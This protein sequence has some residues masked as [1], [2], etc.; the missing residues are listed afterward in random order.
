MATMRSLKRVLAVVA[1]FSCAGVLSAVVASGLPAGAASSGGSGSHVS[2]AA[3]V[4]AYG[5]RA[6]DDAP[7]QRVVI[8][9]GDGPV[10]ERGAA[11]AFPLSWVNP[12]GDDQA[13]Q[14]IAGWVAP[15]QFVATKIVLGRR[16]GSGHLAWRVEGRRAGHAELWLLAPNGTLLSHRRV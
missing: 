6:G 14:V 7:V 15:Q 5:Q 12:L 9:P 10:I 13:V 1:L 8:T 16:N 11:G 2:L 4:R 3:A